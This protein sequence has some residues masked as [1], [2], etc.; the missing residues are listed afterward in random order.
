MALDPDDPFVDA[1]LS[2]HASHA[3][4]LQVLD[5]TTDLG[6]P[7]AAAVSANADGGRIA[8][9]LGAH[10]ERRLAISRALSEVN[11][12]LT[13]VDGDLTECEG[14]LA[15]WLG[16]ATLETESYLQPGDG[17]PRSSERMPVADDLRDDVQAC[18]AALANV[19]LETIV[20]DLTRTDVN[21]TV[22]RVAV[23]GLRHFWARFAPGRLYDVPV[24]LGWLTQ[25]IAEADLN[26]IPFMM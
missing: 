25:P 11:Q 6:I 2:W 1:M 15:T 17:A 10:L 13:S 7:V 23:P 22:A 24:K 16:T 18:V 14:D 21:L 5:L 19:G 12:M 26:P 3:R 8:V 20:L 4:T 9:G